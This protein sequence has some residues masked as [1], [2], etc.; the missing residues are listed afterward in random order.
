MPA[1]IRLSS[2]LPED[3]RDNGLIKMAGRFITQPGESVWAVCRLTTKR[4]TTDLDD[5]QIIPTVR[6]E[7]V[8]PISDDTAAERLEAIADAARDRRTGAKKLPLDVEP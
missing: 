5:N 4:L 8:E 3:D 1:P 6:L 7:M 2:T